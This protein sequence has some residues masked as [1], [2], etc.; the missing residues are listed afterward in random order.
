LPKTQQGVARYKTARRN[1]QKLILL[2]RGKRGKRGN[3]GEGTHRRKRKEK[4]SGINS[5]VG[6]E[7]EWGKW[8]FVERVSG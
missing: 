6:G 2:V 5:T 3:Q 8:W 7:T 1:A 4:Y